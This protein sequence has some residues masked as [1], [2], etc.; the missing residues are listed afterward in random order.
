LPAFEAYVPNALRGW[1][2]TDERHHRTDG[3][4]VFAD[5]SGFTALSERLAAFGRR[6]AELMADAVTAVFTDL[7]AD[8]TARG[9]DLLK[10]GGDALLLAFTGDDHARRAVAAA[11]EMRATLQ[12]RGRLRTPAGSVQLGMSIGVHTGPIDLFLAGNEASH[13]ELVVAGP[14][15]STTVAMEAAA[16]RGE[17]VVSRATRHAIDQDQDH[18]REPRDA[19]PAQPATNDPRTFVPERIRRHL[20]QA[21]HRL[22]TVAFAHLDGVDD[23][24]EADP[25]KAAATLDHDI[26]TI[27]AAFEELGVTF[28]ATDV[29]PGGPKIIAVTGAPQ[30]TELDED[31]ML[32]AL[33][34]VTRHTIL[35]MHTGV[36]R[37]RVFV[38][39]VGPTTRRTYTIIGDA[40]NTAAR[41]MGKAEA[42]GVLATTAV[43]DA[44]T[45]PFRTTAVKPFSAKGKKEKIEAAVVHEPVEDHDEQPAADLPFVGRT[46]ELRALIEKMD[47]AIAG[48]G[49][50]VA[51]V[52]EPGIGKTRLIAEAVAK[53]HH[54]ITTV[55]VR[56]G[57]Y[58]ASS[59]FYA[60]AALVRKAMGPVTLTEAVGRHAP[61]L[62]R[63]LPLLGVV[64]DEDHEA[65][66][67]VDD[68]HPDFRLARLHSVVAQLL[69]A[70]LPRPALVVIEDAQ[71]MDPASAQALAD[72]AP[73]LARKSTVILTARRRGDVGY[74]PS[75]TTATHLDLD[76]LG[77]EH[78]AVLAGLAGRDTNLRT[79]DLAAIAERSAGNPMFLRELLDTATTEG[80][81]E[82]PE[83]VE[84]LV[85]ARVDRLPA[86]ARELLR[87]AAVL[88][89]NVDLD[90]LRQIA[91]DTEPLGHLT[92]LLE[93]NDADG[94]V[95]FRNAL[96]QQVVYET[97]AYRLRTSIHAK[98]AT[99]YERR[100]A[101]A[102]LLA[103]H[104]ARAERHER[105]WVV[106]E[107]AATHAAQRY[108][109]HETAH[110]LRVAI[111]SGRRA[112]APH[113]EL[114]ALWERLGDAYE[115][116]GRYPEAGAAYTAARRLKGPGQA[117]LIRKLGE[118]DERTGRYTAALRRYRAGMTATGGE[119]RDWAELALAYAGVRIRQ[120]RF[121]DAVDWCQ[122]GLEQTKADE[123]QATVAH[124][125][126]LLQ[127]A[128]TRLGTDDRARYRG[129][130]VRLY[131]ELGDQSGLAKALNND[132]LDAY[133]EGRWDDALAWWERARAA[134]ARVGDVVGA[135]T[136]AN[137][138]AEIRSDQGH[139]EEAEALFE[140]A[141]VVFRDAGHAMLRAIAEKNLGR[142]AGRAG[143]H[144]EARQRLDTAEAELRRIGA[145]D[146]RLEAE[147]FRA[148]VELNA[149]R[150]ADT[151]D[152]LGG[153]PSTPLVERIR[154]YARLQL[155]DTAGARDAFD[156]SLRI[157]RDR[158]MAYEEAM[159]LEALT[160]LTGS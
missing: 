30:A 92:A 37:G 77:A 38:G 12:R 127:H 121:A 65:T 48:H 68:L 107:E 4:L 88:G 148:E 135:A 56:C 29:G 62:E 129:M 158:K 155:G 19:P 143:R 25:T 141:A 16:D 139:L 108:A 50:E 45:T 5:L 3:T 17:I 79:T 74:H 99:V 7:Q 82:L 81:D 119:G 154:G 67:S 22:V 116:A 105:A 122:R 152:R 133:Y 93:R 58:A 61:E 150:P 51:I 35:P 114:A 33:L 34:E 63:W 146:Y 145:H 66:Q 147:V 151:L 117:R 120:G 69:Q 21:E 95:R 136:M 144:D 113:A 60:L 96:V 27:D 111:D 78:I 84:K 47:W 156:E 23:L 70:L 159:T 94:T 83:N 54:A 53:R 26:R 1:G 131:D 125:Y 40:V 8:A 149:G 128:H 106:A 100:H 115:T 98:A 140:E 32:L 41:V 137:N 73:R 109:H 13:L 43:L 91:D 20:D 160:A 39:D 130:A 18:D 9:G 42:A 14:T 49:A 118:V 153:L 87:H 28:L 103:V 101:P 10:Y 138:I 132:G 71:W 102:E 11:H 124:A 110:F 6:G 72:I 59:A 104:L 2:A 157:A 85:A 57:P 142:V 75:L 55:A 80:I 76:P 24:I 46:D 97:L 89:V 90:V 86:P 36:H 64:L 15:A 126:F 44:V 112:R 123:E 134:C 52:G 31:R